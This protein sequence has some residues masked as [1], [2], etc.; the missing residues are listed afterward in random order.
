MNLDTLLG[1]AYKT[2]VLK[3]QPINAATALK[4]ALNGDDD[5]KNEAKD[6]LA[7][8]TSRDGA[9]VQKRCYITMKRVELLKAALA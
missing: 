6:F 2:A 3:G 9:E 7:Q 1:D 4:A 8:Y 5:L